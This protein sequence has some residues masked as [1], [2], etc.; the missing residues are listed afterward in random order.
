MYKR[1]EI[2]FRDV[3]EGAGSL[4]LA[5][6]AMDELGL[7]EPDLDAFGVDAFFWF[8]EKGWEEY[9]DKLYSFLMYAKDSRE[10]TRLQVRVVTENVLDVAWEDEFQVAAIDQNRFQDLI[11][12]LE[13]V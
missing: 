2:M 3:W 13:A 1:I 12:L 9:G 10:Y 7:P 4:P 5:A 11:H 6:M 8:K